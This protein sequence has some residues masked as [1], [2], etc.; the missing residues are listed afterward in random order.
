LKKGIVAILLLAFACWLVWANKSASQ[1]TSINV[2]HAQQETPKEA[3]YVS[4]DIV[5]KDNAIEKPT[6]PPSVAKSSGGTKSRTVTKVPVPSTAPKPVPTPP[7]VGRSYSK[8]EVIQLIKDYSA[9]YRISSAI[10]LAIARC[11]SG[12]NQ[13]SK[14]KSSTASGVFQYLSSTWRNTP[15]GRQGISVFDA[16]ANVKM[17]V[18]SIAA[19]G[20][21]P[22]LASRHCWNH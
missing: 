17:A 13:F 4:N 2:V 22:W 8:D 1:E 7:A 20:T 18:S 11:E 19:N 15:A 12:Y 3:D 5:I 16:D 9:A 14:N 10:P 6:N 21:A